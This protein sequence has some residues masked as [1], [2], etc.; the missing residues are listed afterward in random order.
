MEKYDVLIL[1]SGGSDS[2]LLLEMAIATGLKP[3]CLFIDYG[4]RMKGEENE[5]MIKGCVKHKVPQ[6]EV[7]ISGLEVDSGLTGNLE[8]GKY[9]NVHSMYMPR[10]N[11]IFLSIASSVAENLGINRI[12]F[13]PD[14][15]DNLNA[16]PD[17]KQE[18]INK[19]NE[20]SKVNGSTT[21]TVEAPV[22][23]LTKEMVI[24][25]LDKIYKLEKT[26]YFS[27]YGMV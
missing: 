4:Q 24:E 18:F 26:E 25:H 5:K 2:R 8:P 16:F 27:G 1:Y 17:C 21:I 10:R 9:E 7:K 15:S 6:Q 3:Y 13:G 14:W 20:L 22:L 23:G 11:S 19:F 12:W